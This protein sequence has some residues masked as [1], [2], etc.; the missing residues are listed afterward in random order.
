MFVL[1]S[2]MAP[3]WTPWAQYGMVR[4]A[5]GAL[6]GAQGGPMSHFDQLWLQFVSFC[7]IFHDFRNDDSP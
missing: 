4:G 5:L 3:F 6:W 2:K 7:R 1:V